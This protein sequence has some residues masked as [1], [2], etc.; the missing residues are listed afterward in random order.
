MAWSDPRRLRAWSL[1]HPC[2]QCWI[3]QFNLGP[4]PSCGPTPRP[5]LSP[6]PSSSPAPAQPQPHA[7]QLQ[8]LSPH[9]RHQF[10]PRFHSFIGPANPSPDSSSGSGF[11]PKTHPSPAPG[12]WFPGRRRLTAEQ[13]RRLA[14]PLPVRRLFLALMMLTRPYGAGRESC[15][16]L[17]L[18]PGG[19]GSRSEAAR[20]IHTKYKSD[21]HEFSPQFE[22]NLQAVRFFPHQVLKPLLRFLLDLL[23]ERGRSHLG[24]DPG[25]TFAPSSSPNKNLPPPCLR[26]KKICSKLQKILG[27]IE[28]TLWTHQWSDPRSVTRP[29][30]PDPITRPRTPSP[31]PGPRHQTPDPVTRPRIRP[32]GR[33]T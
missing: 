17:G 10:Q 1:L 7:A 27:L 16:S 2:S 28:T 19:G 33:T 26:C 6:S 21:S 8:S 12:S 23:W 14:R 30:T 11:S 25:R 13:T 29:Q 32:R 22:P 31:D 4:G 24:W 5:G 3:F 18:L 20:L 15:G 9:P